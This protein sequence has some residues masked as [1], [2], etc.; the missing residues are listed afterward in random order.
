VSVG[1]C[2]VVDQILRIE[3]ESQNTRARHEQRSHTLTL[4]RSRPNTDEHAVDSVLSSSVRCTTPAPPH[5]TFE[6]SYQVLFVSFYICTR[7][8][9]QRTHRLVDSANV[10]TVKFQEIIREGQSTI[11]RPIAVLPANPFLTSFT[12]PLQVARMK[13]P[14]VRPLDLSSASHLPHCF[15][16]PPVTR[17]SF[18]VSIRARSV[19][20]PCFVPRSPP[21]AT[22]RRGW[23]RTG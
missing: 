21:L 22:N 17:S 5:R 16:S 19:S 4:F 10:P 18:A 8:S 2:T 20:Q 6:S 15:H 12:Q 1:L 14:T 3:A 23:R 13:V 11:V 7:L 9:S